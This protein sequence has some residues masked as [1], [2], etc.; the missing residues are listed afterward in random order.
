MVSSRVALLLR[1]DWLF[2]GQ[3][4]DGAVG[5]RVPHHLTG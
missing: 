5:P 3:W 1:V 4:N 2:A